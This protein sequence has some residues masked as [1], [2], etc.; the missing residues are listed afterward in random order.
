MD[1]MDISCSMTVERSGRC[2]GAVQSEAERIVVGRQEG[3]FI[4]GLVLLQLEPLEG[5]LR[6]ILLTMF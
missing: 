4:C 5:T 6:G 2:E 1:R 3:S